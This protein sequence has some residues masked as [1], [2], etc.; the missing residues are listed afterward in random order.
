MESTENR[1][2]VELQASPELPD[3]TPVAPPELPPRDDKPNIKPI[4]GMSTS[5]ST[6]FIFRQSEFYGMPRMSSQ[7]NVYTNT[8]IDLQSIVAKLEDK[9]QFWL[10][11]IECYNDAFVRRNNLPGLEEKLC[12]SIPTSLRGAVYAKVLQIKAVADKQTYSNLVKSAKAIKIDELDTPSDAAPTDSHD[13]LR[14][15]KYCISQSEHINLY[16]SRRRAFEFI[17]GITPLLSKFT[18]FEDGEILALLFR[19]VDL[20]SRFSKD[21]MAYK[22]CRALEDVEKSHYLHII[23]QG[24]DMT[25]FFCRALGQ[26]WKSDIDDILR[27]KMLDFIVFE[28]FDSLLRLL[29]AHFVRQGEKISSLDRDDLSDYL[30]NGDFLN[31]IDER[32][33]KEMTSIEFPVIVYE[34]E[35]HLMNANSISSNDQELINMKEVF[36]DLVHKKEDIISQ[37]ESLRKTHLEI[38][39]QNEDFQKQLTEAQNERENLTKLQSSLQEQYAR[40]TMKENLRNTVKANEDISKSNLELEQQIS[41]LEVSIEKKKA[42]LAKHGL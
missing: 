18:E 24:I 30:V 10:D 5:L 37:L 15:L 12:N 4:Y 8:S 3:K 19:F 13:I 34:N 42:K 21:E 1:P 25:N 22:G 39:A 17:A 2:D 32:T 7:T 28:G 40:L 11:V 14:V 16:E 6:T 36:D 26:F 33:F 27:V 20:Y 41:E 29:I 35:F 9:D 38:Q 31:S 23:T